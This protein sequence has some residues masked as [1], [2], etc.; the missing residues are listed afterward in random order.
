MSSCGFSTEW[1]AGRRLRLAYLYDN[2]CDSRDDLKE[3][4]DAATISGPK[5]QRSW[6][7]SAR[8]CVCVVVKCAFRLVT[9]VTSARIHAGMAITVASHRRRIK[10]NYRG[11]L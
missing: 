8:Q 4:S 3:N 9:S 5:D 2:K 11:V 10:G 6:W 1:T 7:R